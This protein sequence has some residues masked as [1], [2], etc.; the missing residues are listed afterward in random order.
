MKTKRWAILL[1]V[2]CTVFTS[3]AQL[4]YKY[5]ADRSSFNLLS[6]LTNPFILLGFFLYGCGVILVIIAL[7]GGAVTVLYPIITTSYL[8]VALGSGFF[9]GEIITMLRW[10]GIL[11][12]IAG[13]I[14][15]MAN[16]NK[17][18]A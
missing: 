1:M 9:F 17:V 16:E 4:L 13:I 15:I 10:L 11:L 5:G 12:I 18:N 3:F 7:R 6:L 2:L 8:W 14:T